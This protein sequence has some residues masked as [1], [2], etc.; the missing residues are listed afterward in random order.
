MLLVMM[1]MPWNEDYASLFSRQDQATILWWIPGDFGFDLFHLFNRY[2]AFDIKFFE[3]GNIDGPV[4]GGDMMIHNHQANIDFLP[5]EN[6]YRVSGNILIDHA[7]ESFF[8]QLMIVM[9]V[10]TKL[11]DIIFF[12]LFHILSSKA[13]HSM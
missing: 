4:T 9:N 8:H 13:M 3:R 6:K 2:Q 10:F 1:L 7:L 11:F 12:G 5:M